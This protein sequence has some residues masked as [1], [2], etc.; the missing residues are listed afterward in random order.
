MDQNKLVT[1]KAKAEDVPFIFAT[2]LKGLYHGNAYYSEIEKE[3]YFSNYHKVLE[4]VLARADTFVVC[5]ADAP[6]V[7]LGYSVTEGPVLHWVFVKKSW[8]RLGIAR[9]LLP[10]TIE[11]VTHLTKLG[12]KLKP[13][14]WLFNPFL[15]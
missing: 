14:Q 9:W 13:A 7:I 3:A 15:L 2:W 6:D 1:R 8:R 4:H 11:R 5:L 10:P 12:S